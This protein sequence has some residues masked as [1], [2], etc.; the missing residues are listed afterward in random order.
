MSKI[1]PFS[2]Y[3]FL[4]LAP[5]FWSGNFVMGRFMHSEIPP[6]SLAFFRWFLVILILMPGNYSNLRR[7]WP[8]IKKNFVKITILSILSIVIYTSFVYLGLHDTTV[9]SA[10]LINA[11][12]PV[13]MVL[14]SFFLISDSLSI[15][16]LFG[17][18]LSVLGVVFII[19]K[20]DLSAITKI[21]YNLGDLVILFA[22]GSWALFSVLYKKMELK[23]TP[24]LF[25][26]VTAIIGDLILLPCAIVEHQMGYLT[27]YGWLSFGS[28]LYASLFSS[29]LAFTFWNIGVREAGPG[30]AAYFFNLLPVFG[31]VLAIL[32]LGE[33]VHLYHLYGCL[34]VFSGILLATKKQ[35]KMRRVVSSPGVEN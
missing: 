5:L 25:L 30:I 3:I 1:K 13:L 22:A 32:F 27:Q 8:E 2:A 14:L 4:I 31:S 11:T 21:H 20:G 33:N 7:N 34:F 35:I 17:I 16:K 28:V 19:T 24:F 26:L 29:V 23:L 6:F 18:S 9:L 12:V 10:S 15:H